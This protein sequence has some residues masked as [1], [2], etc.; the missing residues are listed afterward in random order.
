MA[1]G[2]AADRVTLAIGEQQPVDAGAVLLEVTTEFGQNDVG[3]RDRPNARLCGRSAPEACPI[4]GCLPDGISICRPN[5]GS[6]ATR[7]GCWRWGF[8]GFFGDQ[9][10]RSLRRKLDKA[11]TLAECSQLQVLSLVA[12]RL[13]TAEG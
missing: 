9:G 4:R 10:R 8:R 5:D 1:E 6:D 11:E 2:V 12:M 13:L 7:L 3:H